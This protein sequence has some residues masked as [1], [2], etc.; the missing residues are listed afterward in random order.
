MRLDLLQARAIRE[1]GHSQCVRLQPKPELYSV[2][3]LECGGAAGSVEG[4]EDGVVGGGVGT[5]EP[6]RREGKVF[7]EA[8]GEMF[9]RLGSIWGSVGEV[10]A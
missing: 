10:G 7:W 1:A 8:D 9:T 6:R 4:A 3:E 2:H 5:G